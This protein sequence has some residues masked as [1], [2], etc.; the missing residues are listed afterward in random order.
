MRREMLLGTIINAAAI[1]V[2][3]LI[4]V[5]IRNVPEEISKLIM[6]ALS[7]AL[8]V[9]GIQMAVTGE[10]FLIIII[11]LTSGALLGSWL[12]IDERL[13]QLGQWLGTKIGKNSQGNVAQAFVSSTLI[14][15]TG[16]MAIIGPL[17][18]ALRGDH[19]LLF[20][21]SSIDGFSALIIS[22][23]LGIGV[24]FAAIPVFLYQASIT[25]LANQIDAFV[26]NMLMDMIIAEITCIGGILI[27]AIGLNLLNVINVKIANLLP[28]LVIV[29]LLVVSFQRL[30]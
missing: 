25:L 30:L 4:G 8:I 17:E 1:A 14:F 29:V 12:Q 3:S 13:N 19:S 26:P 9:I 27:L 22:S 2:A 15:A 16:A 24:F 21:K 5:R 18:A 10:N 6:Q 28:S 23:T 7:L 20:T 11:S